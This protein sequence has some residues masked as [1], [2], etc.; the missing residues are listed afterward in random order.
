MQ[1]DLL[2]EPLEIKGDEWWVAARNKRF[3]GG[4]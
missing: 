1:F 3:G 4:V 2:D